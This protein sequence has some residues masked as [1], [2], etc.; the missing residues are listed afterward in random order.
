MNNKLN[1]LIFESQ[2]NNLKGKAIV[3]ATYAEK[4]YD[5]EGNLVPESE[6]AD[7]YV[8]QASGEFDNNP[9]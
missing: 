2:R 9:D 1:K 8:R 7:Y 5:T 6:Y 4:I 3:F